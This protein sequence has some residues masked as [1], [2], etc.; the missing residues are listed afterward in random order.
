M[1]KRI[2][3]LRTF[4]LFLI[5]LVASPAFS[6]EAV[7]TIEIKV[8]PGLQFDLVRFQVQPGTKVKLVFTNTDDMDHNLLI[9][10]PGAR[11]EVVN[12]AI[13]LAGLGPAR[14]YIPE[15]TGV[16]WAIP[17]VSSEQSKSITF[18]APKKEGVY[19]YVCTYP[20]QGFVMYGAMYVY[21]K[22]EMPKLSEDLNIPNSRRGVK[23]GN[24]TGEARHHVSATVNSAR[25]PVPPYLYRV[26]I[27]GA[28][29]AAIA[30][31]LTD[32]LS[33]CWDA[34]VSKLR[35]AWKGGFVDNTLLWKGHKNAAATIVGT[36][37]YRDQVVYP[38]RINNKDARVEYKGY[39]LINRYPEFHYTVNGLDVYE[40]IKPIETAN[41]FARSFRIP[42]IKESICF[43][44]DEN[45]GMDYQS[46]SGKRTT[47][48][49]ELNADQAKLFT[50]IMTERK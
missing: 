44:F 43:V 38:L 41:G 47:G 20:G 26:Y 21:S 5:S 30:V 27:D 34:G 17:I 36:V 39:R 49:V 18:T 25:K 48:K 45:D 37:F 31:S 12:A 7:K 2:K 42:E 29:P 33:Y 10:K 15:S 50:I 11:E 16:L 24:E 6:Q 1:D 19:P 3:I 32:S 23:P 35:F 8:L 14:N 13:Q 40:L 46:D 28:S 4:L 22:D 9:T